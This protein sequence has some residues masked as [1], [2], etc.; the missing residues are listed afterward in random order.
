M[1]A[2]LTQAQ[3]P[4]KRSQHAKERPN[5]KARWKGKWKWVVG[6][7]T[8]VVLG[9]MLARDIPVAAWLEGIAQPLREMGWLGVLAYAGI[10]FVVGM[11]CLPCLPLTLMSGYIFGMTGGV[12]AVHTGATLA[13]ACGFLVGRVAG[14]RHAAEYL[15]HSKRFHFLE[16]AIAK[17]GWKIVALLRMH[18][19]PF[20]LSNLLYGMTALEFWHYLLATTL[21][22]IPGHLIYV[23]LGKVG[24]RYLEK[25]ELTNMG[26]AEWTAAALSI[27]S[28]VLLGFVVTRMVRKYGKVRE[29]E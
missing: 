24:G 11:L 25:A 14:R 19:I 26:P 10:Y 3:E 1:S 12:I 27:G 21:A 28:A 5:Q 16:K 22:M 17:E 8:M 4:G 15:R 29:M 2:P 20:G 7:F 9:L 6:L 18:A 13:A 23:Y